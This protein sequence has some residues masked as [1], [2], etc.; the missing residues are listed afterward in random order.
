MRVAGVVDQR[1]LNCVFGVVLVTGD[2]EGKTDETLRREV[3][4][5]AERIDSTGGESVRT[6]L[7]A[8]CKIVLTDHL[9]ERCTG[10]A[11]LSKYL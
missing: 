11:G 1:G 10:A 9:T 3:K 6:F 4:Q 7:D 5:R 8:R 2:G